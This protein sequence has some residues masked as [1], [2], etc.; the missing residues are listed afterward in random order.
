M[1]S[2]ATSWVR[3]HQI[4]YAFTRLEVENRDAAGRVELNNI[5]EA[6]GSSF[7]KPDASDGAVFEEDTHVSKIGLVSQIQGIFSDLGSGSI[8]RLLEYHNNNSDRVI[9]DLLDDALPAH[10]KTAD[11]SEN[12]IPSSFPAVKNKSLGQFAP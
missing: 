9:A 11:R 12:M 4:R 5:G 3:S 1:P 6:T 2:Y 7:S 10:L 8:I